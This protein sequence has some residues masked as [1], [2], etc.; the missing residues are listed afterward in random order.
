M[1]S[2]EVRAR[3]RSEL[4][5]DP[6]GR[7][8]SAQDAHEIERVALAKINSGESWESV[9]QDYFARDRWGF[10]PREI[11]KDRPTTLGLKLLLLAAVTAT[12]GLMAIVWLGQNLT[13]RGET[14]DLLWFLAAVG[15]L[16]GLYVV[17]LRK[18]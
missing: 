7:I 2:N 6:E 18:S 15:S 1:N 14:S 12:F 5:S 17:L 11:P 10:S 8:Y 9:R 4:L 16:I 13:N 3:V